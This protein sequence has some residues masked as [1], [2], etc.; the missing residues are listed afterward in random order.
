MTDTLSAPTTRSRETERVRSIMDR[1]AP[2]Y[3]RQMGR[4][5]K[6]LFAGGRDWVCSRVHGEVLE[7]AIGT[8]LNLPHYPAGVR[9]TGMELSPKMLQLAEARAQEMGM[10][11]NLR[12]G[13]VQALD[14]P[15]ASF[16]TVVC[17]FALCNIPD[18][19]VAVREAFR[20][21][22]PGGL[23]VLV[24]HVRST[25]WWVRA[26]QRVW[27]VFSVRLEGDHVLREP[28]DHLR[29]TGFAIEEQERRKLGLVERI[30]ARKPS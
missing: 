24:E 11:V 22:R 8:G 13:D 21:L 7:I 23:F 1:L 25:K 20:V 27:N 12:L 2:G 14:F 3:D 17:T 26:V 30:A 5:D 19:R 18:D 15:D 9:L 29:A 4:F 16:D 28:L 6:L 10:Q